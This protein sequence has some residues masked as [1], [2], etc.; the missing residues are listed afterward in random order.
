[1]DGFSVILCSTSSDSH[2]W[3]L[4]FMEL[5]L[6][7]AGCAVLNLGPCTPDDLV[8]AECERLEPDL[9]VISTV[10]GHGL[11]D[12]TRLIGRLRETPGGSEVP[13]VIGGK[14]T[15]DG[16]A[17]DRVAEL[18]AAGATAVFGDGEADVEAF[19]EFVVSLHSKVRG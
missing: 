4:V 8:A 9:V 6:A 11:T 2:T 19:A 10:N 16:A 7:E 12:G 1:M 17:L 5:L 15:V 3:N 18:L 14:L 13:V